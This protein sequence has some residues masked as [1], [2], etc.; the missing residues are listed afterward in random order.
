V[1]GTW[2]ANSDGTYS[3]NTT[4]TGNEQFTLASSCLVISSTP[5][6]C[7]GAAGL[8]TSVLGYSKLDCPSTADGGC[9][10]S[11][12]AKQTG[13]IGV[14]S[15]SPPT[16]DNYTTSGNVLTISGGPD[17]VKYSYCVSGNKLTLTPQSTKPVMTG[18]IVLQKSGTT[19]GTGGPGG[20]STGAGG[21]STTAS[22]DCTDTSTYSNAVSGQYGASTITLDGNSSK[23]YYM[24]AD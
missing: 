7:D 6:K 17:D 10:C 9:S 19:P 14:L 3:D 4:T 5:V 12:T 23:T 13:G 18:M 2:T 1:T 11:A 20:A 8:L 15:M 16:S 21:S 22:I 24:Q